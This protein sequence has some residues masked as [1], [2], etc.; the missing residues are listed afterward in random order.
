M[1]RL[2]LYYIAGFF[3]LILQ[4]TL[5]PNIFSFTTP[6]LLL[7]LVI[8]I[9]L[10]ERYLRGSLLTFFLGCLSDVFSGNTLGLNCTVYLLAFVA[11]RSV[12][13][14]LNT[15]SSL[16]LLF[17]VACGTLFQGAVLVFL[18]TFLAE[19]GGAW[20]LILKALPLQLISNVVATFLL[21]S[22]LQKVQ[23]T[24]FPRIKIP[25]LERLDQRYE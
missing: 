1:S 8:Y 10:N 4:T 5:L 11:I 6:D 7:I 16:L 13:S 20:F 24:F 19:T 25:G 2:I 12:V 3:A 23:K 9:G 21:L 18:L 17:M 14:R 15:E 22:I